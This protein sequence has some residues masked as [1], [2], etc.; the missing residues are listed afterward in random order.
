MNFTKSV[1]IGITCF[2]MVSALAQE[3]KPVERM[4][5]EQVLQKQNE[6]ELR[7]NGVWY[8]DSVVT[9]NAAGERTDVQYYNNG[10]SISYPKVRLLG[11]GFVYPAGA[12]RWYGIYIPGNYQYNTVYDDKNNLILVEF[13]NY[14]T[15]SNTY[16]ITY[17]ITYNENNNPVLIEQYNYTMLRGIWHYEYNADGYMTLFER[18]WNGPDD[19]LVIVDDMPK[20]TAEFDAQGRPV[21]MR[22][23]IGSSSAND[24]LLDSYIL[25]YYSD[26]T[27]QNEQIA[28]TGSTAYLIDQTLYIQ[29]A[30]ADR[31][32]VYSITGNQLY[33][34]VIEPGINTVNTASLPQGILLVKAN[35]GWV[36]K[37]V[38][39]K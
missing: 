15:N 37:V 2:C 9:Y 20:Y 18:Y 27:T 23:Y 10:Y 24:W 1:C 7:A 5:E 38:N 33:E 22:N 36:T 21:E 4:V 39:R 28:S 8:P 16:M 13:G 29:S 3:N 26:G 30:K 32:T 34:T 14:D 35:S 17:H 31:I 6:I 25:F 11:T 19:K 12:G